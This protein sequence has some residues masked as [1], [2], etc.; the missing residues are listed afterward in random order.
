MPVGLLSALLFLCLPLNPRA[1]RLCHSL[2]SAPGEFTNAQAL[3][4]GHS[5]CC[6]LQSLHPRPALSPE[7]HL[8]QLCMRTF[9]PTPYHGKHLW[10][11]ESPK[12]SSFSLPPPKSMG[13]AP[14]R[15]SDICPHQTPRGPPPVTLTMQAHWHQTLI[16]PPSKIYIKISM[17]LCSL[18]DRGPTPWYNTELS[19]DHETRSDFNL[20]LFV[21]LLLFSKISSTNHLLT[22][23][24]NTCHSK[25]DP[26]G[27]LTQ[28][29]K[30]MNSC[31][32]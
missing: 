7:L 24:L 4:L 3:A 25:C 2:H 11:D 20:F 27:D 31:H 12:Q 26:Q 5:M 6:A 14:S 32:L 29:S 22:T 13:S 8:Y 9:P 30:R 17:P 19:L 18:L 23:S 10:S 21:C 16:A 28:S 15:H 1:Q